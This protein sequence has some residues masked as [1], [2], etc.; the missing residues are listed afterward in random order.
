MPVT[1]ACAPHFLTDFLPQLP[2][3]LPGAPEK[4]SV[5][6]GRGMSFPAL[7]RQVFNVSLYLDCRGPVGSLTQ[8]VWDHPVAPSVL[9]GAHIQS[10]LTGWAQGESLQVD[11]AGIKGFRPA[12]PPLRAPL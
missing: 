9:H 10:E 6:L 1:P 4:G 5:I 3:P 11:G 7:L 8:Q 2:I 12:V